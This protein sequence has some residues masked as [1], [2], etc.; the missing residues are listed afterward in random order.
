M[1]DSQ[2]KQTAAA[3]RATTVNKQA[4][5]SCNKVILIAQQ[6]RDTI[7]PSLDLNLKIASCKAVW[8][9][10]NKLNDDTNHHSLDSIKKTEKTEL[11]ITE[12]VLKDVL[13]PLM[14]QTNE[15][16]VNGCYEKDPIK[17]Q[18]DSMGGSSV[19]SGFSKQANLLAPAQKNSLNESHSSSLSQS[20]NNHVNNIE[21][22]FETASFNNK[23]KIPEPNEF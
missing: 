11:T 12:T 10:P 8:E 23:S 9:N 17:T 20:S 4:L 16:L 14:K 19:F 3:A 21:P 22:F 2:N 7:S 1:L 6:E 5:S 13:E 15:P 18:T